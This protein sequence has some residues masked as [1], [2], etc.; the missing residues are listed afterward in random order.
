MLYTYMLYAICYMLYAICYMLY[1]IY[2]AFQIYNTHTE[3]LY[4]VGTV[5]NNPIAIAI[6]T[7][8]YTLYTVAHSHCTMAIHYT[9]YTVAIAI[10][11]WQ[12]TIQTT[13]K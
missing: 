2:S 11:P 8:H 13:E 9:L 4:T 12:Y 5:H 3:A 1:A 10:A 7:I 6:Y